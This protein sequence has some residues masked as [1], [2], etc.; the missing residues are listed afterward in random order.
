MI[1]IL[2][3]YKIT[4]VMVLMADSTHSLQTR[5]GNFFETLYIQSLENV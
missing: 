3:R 2:V 5:K 1:K 4:P